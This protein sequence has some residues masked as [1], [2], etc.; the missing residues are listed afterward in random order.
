M[1]NK[2]I[3]KSKQNNNYRIF[4]INNE[5]NCIRHFICFTES[6]FKIRLI[7][8]KEYGINLFIVIK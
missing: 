1:E 7:N 3:I 5:T 6:I 4:W 8:N 2:F